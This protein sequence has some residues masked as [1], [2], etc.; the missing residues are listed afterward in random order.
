MTLIPSI[1]N[2]N[3][4]A[5]RSVLDELGEGH[6]VHIDIE[7][8]NF[9]SNISF[10]E[11]TLNSIIEYHS[12]PFDV[13]LLTTNP[14]TYLPLLFSHGKKITH[15]CFHIEAGEYPLELLTRIR[16]HGYKAGLALNMKTSI[17]SLFM[18]ADEI[19]YLIVMTAEPDGQG[20]R[21]RPKSVERIRRIR[22]MLPSETEIWADGGIGTEE[23]PLLAGCGVDTAILGRAAYTGPNVRETLKKLSGT[24]A[25]IPTRT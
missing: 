2:A 8:G 11:R 12:G 18:L 7:D 23:L 14:G 9:V 24:Q 19:D 13:H 6:P 5:L 20:N 15:I 17:E 3:P 21:F 1:A 22:R 16:Q 25:N 4:L 10:G